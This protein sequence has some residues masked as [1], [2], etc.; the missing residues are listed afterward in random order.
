MVE[1]SEAVAGQP[2]MSKE[3]ARLFP[4]KLNAPLRQTDVG[5]LFHRVVV[6][7]SGI[8]TLFHVKLL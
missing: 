5:A 1:A 3:T 6:P 4:K 2:R 8:T 7:L